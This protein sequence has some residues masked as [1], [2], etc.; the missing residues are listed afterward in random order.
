MNYRFCFDL[1][2]TLCELKLK[3]Q[4][5]SEVLPK[6]GAVEYLKSLKDSGHYIIILTARNMLTHNNN[7]GKIIANQA[8]IVIEW[9]KK[10]NFIY[11]ELHFGKPY[12]DYYI[13][14]KAIQFTNFKKLKK[15]IKL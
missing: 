11:D 4:E 9:L 15:Q 3:D 6:P 12:A 13:D 1:D 7:I 2:N 8:P 10:H 14:D 5:Y